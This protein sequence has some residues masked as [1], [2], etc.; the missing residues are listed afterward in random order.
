MVRDAK[1]EA[2]FSY[3]GRW[4]VS[5]V[6]PSRSI[7]SKRVR[8]IKQSPSNYANQLATELK[9]QGRD[10]ISLALGEPDFPTPEHIKEAAIEAMRLNQTRYT[11]VDGITALKQA[12]CEKFRRENE[13][14]YKPEQISIGT[15]GKQVIYNALLCTLDPGD[16]I[17]VPAPYWVSYTDMAV[18]AEAVP[19]KVPC[20]PE[21]GFKLQPEQLE[22][23]ITPRTRWLMLNSPNNPSGAVYSRDE[24]K[25]LAEVLL[26][27]PHVWVMT[28][29]MYEHLRYDGIE[30]ATIAQV[31]PRLYE[32][33]LTVN[34]VSK[35]YAMTGW[36]IGFGGGAKV[37][38]DAMR[39]MQSQCTSSPNSIAQ[40]AA[41]AALSGPQGFFAERAA[42][43]QGRRDLVVEAVN[44]IPGLSCPKPQGA[45]YVF[46]L[47][48][49]WIGKR[50]PQGKVLATDQDVAIYLLEGAE[51]AVVQGNAYGV[52]P[53]FRISYATSMELLEEGLAR[54]RRAGG[55]LA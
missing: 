20:L 30:F 41:I 1:V 11:T 10:I 36:R 38:I 17:I 28:D 9:A 15:G 44:R 55:Q 43:F 24:L 7:L 29:D 25:A 21:H 45:F 37:L 18:L 13:L 39:K 34:G 4:R 31:E 19:V 48:S 26:R 27:H 12:V 35:A 49:G 5:A 51:V 23:A 54:I 22:R 47:C 46:P 2:E 33:T 52:S 14:E 40:M 3:C 50:T 6:D 8:S 16:E 32:R 53:N 42:I